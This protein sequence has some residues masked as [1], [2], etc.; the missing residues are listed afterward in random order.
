MRGEN[1]YV[2]GP[3]YWRTYTHP[4]NDWEEMHPLFR[5]LWGVFVI[6]WV[7]LPMILVFMKMIGLI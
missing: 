5:Y 1:K 7:I 6:A 3:W 4:V 2:H